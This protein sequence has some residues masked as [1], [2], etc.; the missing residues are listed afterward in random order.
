VGSLEPMARMWRP[1]RVIWRSTATATARRIVSHTP[2][3]TRSQ[4]R[5]GG[6]AVSRSLS[7]VV[8]ATTIVSP[9]SPFA[10]PRRPPHIPSVTM[11]GGSRRP[12]T[13]PPIRPP[14][15]R[16]PATVATTAAA[17]DQPRARSDASVTVASAICA[18]TERSMPPLAITRVIP[19][20]AVATTAVCS[21]MI[22]RFAGVANC[23]GRS[24][25]KRSTTTAR[26]AR[27]PS[28]CSQV[29]IRVRSPPASGS[30]RRSR[31]SAAPARAAPGT[32]P[33]RGRRPRGVP[34][35]G[36]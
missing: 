36:C 30:A 16:P 18:P 12:V 29:F 25:V 20:A 1:S 7:H 26:P 13:S 28:L 24:A 8:G 32:S 11:N 14:Q 23:P 33:P 6:S 31:R 9:A 3:G 15:A 34:A 22:S 2:D 5:S 19:S 27:G 21:S 17:G 10:R 4:R 35:R